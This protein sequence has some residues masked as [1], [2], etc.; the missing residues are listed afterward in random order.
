MNVTADNPALQWM[1]DQTEKDKL[2]L[3]FLFAWSFGLVV[4]V[5]IIPIMAYLCCVHRG[6]SMWN[7]YG[8][9][10]KMMPDDI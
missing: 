5:V 8:C 10:C 4:I 6:G 3:I 9:C 1:L 2:Q 7:K